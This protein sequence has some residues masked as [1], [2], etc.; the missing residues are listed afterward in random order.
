MELFGA[1]RVAHDV[2][3]DLPRRLAAVPLGGMPEQARDRRSMASLREH[4]VPTGRDSLPTPRPVPR[5]HRP[6]APAR[7]AFRH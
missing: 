4:C 1:G 2:V 6:L 7:A 3:R 5:G